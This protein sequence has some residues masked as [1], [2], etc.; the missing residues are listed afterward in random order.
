[1]SVGPDSL[2]ATENGSLVTCSAEGNPRPNITW[3]DVDEKNIDTLSICNLTKT[4]QWMERDFFGDI[5]AALEFN[6][7]ASNGNQTDTIKYRLKQSPQALRQI[8]GFRTLTTQNT[9]T[10]LI[11]EG[12]SINLSS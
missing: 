7:S 8:C 2:R 1:L 4:Q 9:I 12:K 3:T 5:E 11:Y 6:C 10:Q